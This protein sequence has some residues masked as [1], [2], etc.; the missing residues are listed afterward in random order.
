M[1]GCEQ[2][3]REDMLANP[4]LA[5][6]IRVIQEKLRLTQEQIRLMV[7]RAIKEGRPAN[8]RPLR[9]YNREDHRFRVANRISNQALRLLLPN[10]KEE[11][12]ERDRLL[13]RG[14]LL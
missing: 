5:P 14:I 3:L 6:Y 8:T 1:K 4:F 10:L 7:S 9:P 12:G 11:G 13:G 2:G